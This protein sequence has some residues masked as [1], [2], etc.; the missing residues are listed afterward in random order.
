MKLE[1]QITSQDLSE[2]LRDLGVKQ[3][4][5]F[6]WRRQGGGPWSIATAEELAGAAE[7]VFAPTV[8]ELGEML[9]SWVSVGLRADQK[10]RL[11]I[12]PEEIGWITWYGGDRVI[13]N[14]SEADSRALALIHLLEKK[15]ITVEEVNA[16][17]SA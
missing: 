9:P 8:A 4:G 1:S 11:S 7:F 14:K 2:R 3:L 15:L 16:R 12:W 6:Y 17:L 13:L 5:T 10:Y